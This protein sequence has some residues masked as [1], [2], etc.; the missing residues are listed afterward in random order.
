M[1]Q[2]FL[3]MDVNKKRNA[4]VTEQKSAQRSAVRAE[5][6]L[7]L[8]VSHQRGFGPRPRGSLHPDNRS[9]FTESTT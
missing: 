8:L 5:Q 4:A 2:T 6:E 9:A 7:P 1:N 3:W